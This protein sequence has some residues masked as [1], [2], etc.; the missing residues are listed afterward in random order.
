STVKAWATPAIYDLLETIVKGRR[1]I[2]FIAKH[3]G[4]ALSIGKFLLIRG[5][6]TVK[7]KALEAWGSVKDGLKELVEKIETGVEK[8]E[9]F[10]GRTMERLKDFVGFHDEAYRFA[11]EVG[12]EET[13]ELSHAFDGGG[14]DVPEQA[15]AFR[16]LNGIAL[17]SKEAAEA[18]SKWLSKLEEGKLREILDTGL[19]SEVGEL[20]VNGLKSLQVALEEPNRLAELVEQPKLVSRAMAALRGVK[21]FEFEDRRMSGGSIWLTPTVD[22][23]LYRVR[24]V[25][26][27]EPS[28]KMWTIEVR[29]EGGTNQIT[30][31]G[32]LR[33]ELAGKTIKRL[34]ICGYVP[35]L[36][37]P[38][39]FTLR[40][41]EEDVFLDFVDEA[42]KI[43]GF[44]VEWAGIGETVRDP[45]LGFGLTIETNVKSVERGKPL[46]LRFYEDGGVRCLVGEQPEVR[47][48]VREIEGAS[49]EVKRLGSE[50]IASLILYIETEKGAWESVYPI[51]TLE[52]KVG[53][54]YPMDFSVK[55]DRTTGLQSE[56]RKVF[57]FD[58]VK[59][60][61]NK[62]DAGEIRAKIVF[63]D[64]ATV[65]TS[66]KELVVKTGE[67]QKVV[68]I[69]FYEPILKPLLTIEEAKEYFRKLGIRNEDL[70]DRLADRYFEVL[71]YEAEKVEGTGDRNL[72]GDFGEL[73]IIRNFPQ[74]VID[75]HR[76]VRIEGKLHEIDI[77]FDDGPVESKYWTSERTYKIHF[78]EM[79]EE[80]TKLVEELKTC[81]YEMELEGAKKV[82]LI[83]GKEGVI[84]DVEFNEYMQKLRS[85]L[86]ADTSWLDIHYGIKK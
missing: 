41:L 12:Q 74:K 36:H 83:F 27:G 49:L 62:M 31:P 32:W 35:E 60:V 45:E 54:K 48:D 42:L 67:A 14:L 84:S 44:S 22:E 57:G 86:G 47:I 72:I 10:A 77:V 46:I 69:M 76:R 78:E 8:I 71:G 18:V 63:D 56:V 6:K 70:I 23:G 40:H 64:G 29:K 61:Q 17:K 52:L 68:E 39:H 53:E 55:G 73:E 85:A 26:E 75:T 79:P 28:V 19:L 33:E 5:L 34:E 3:P 20:K 21:Y 80:F 82:Y 25:V 81:K 16:E 50:Q 13:V 1:V 66:G 24:A 51:K 7:C 2:A 38:K 30:V 43:G 65:S 4:E 37:F 15:E 58:A 59:D 9:D 11:K